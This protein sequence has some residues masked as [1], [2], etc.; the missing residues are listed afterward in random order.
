MPK[1]IADLEAAYF[2]AAT[3]YNPLTDNFPGG[4]ASSGGSDI[5]VPSTIVSAQNTAQAL[6]ASANSAVVI[7]VSGRATAMFHIQ[8][9]SLNVGLL[10][11]AS[12]DGTNWFNVAGPVFLNQQTG[13]F[14]TVL[15]AAVTGAFT[16]ACADFEYVRLSTPNSAVTGTATIVAA[17]SSAATVVT[18]DNLLQAGAG[19]P[20]VPAAFALA[21]NTDQSI[22]GANGAR[23]G[24]IIRNDSGQPVF[25]RFGSAAT[26]ILYS[27]L[28][29]NNSS[30]QVP[31]SITSNIHAL[32][33]LAGSAIAAGVGLFV[34]EFTA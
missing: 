11:Q 20:G 17:A 32:S 3:G 4:V 21:A 22:L 9:N 28:I 19:T 7:P 29:P 31:F 18:T 30:Y 2:A 25:I 26:S 12:I 14:Q 15:S 5:L 1:S 13:A 34:T 16:V 10:L 6:A 27:D 8:A 33:T 23:R 24:A